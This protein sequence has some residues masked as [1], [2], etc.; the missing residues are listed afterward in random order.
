MH[1]PSTDTI[2]R[3]STRHKTLWTFIMGTLDAYTDRHGHSDLSMGLKICR[4]T[5]DPEG[6]FGSLVNSWFVPFGPTFVFER[7]FKYAL[8]TLVVDDHAACF[9]DL[10]S[11]GCLR[12]SILLRRCQGGSVEALLADSGHVGRPQAKGFFL[13]WIAVH[14]LEAEE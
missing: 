2:P 14:G 13:L 1:F 7:S 4:I 9:E 6:L 3:D 10:D 8:R 12:W 5:A 11:F